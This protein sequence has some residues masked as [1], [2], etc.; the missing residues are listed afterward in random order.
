MHPFIKLAQESIINYLATGQLLAAPSPLPPQLQQPGAVFVTIYAAG[1]QLRGCRG[2]IVPTEPTLA[3]AIIK[4][5]VASATDDPRF[6][7]MTLAETAAM[8]LKIDLLSPMEPVA[9]VATLN[10][11][12]YGVLIQSPSG[13]RR[14]LLLPNI[15]AVDSVPHQLQL[16]RRKAGM[17]PDEPSE[18]FRFTVTRFQADTPWEQV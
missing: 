16:V 12:I 6:P 3:D 15:D 13:Q 10:E 4:T 7:P 18:L 5:A 1:G 9:D 2:T 14:G 17:S 11:K 8:Q